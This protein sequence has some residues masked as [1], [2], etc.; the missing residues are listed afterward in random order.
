[1]PII[2]LLTDFGT[3]DG[4]VGE[5]KGVLLSQA[6]DAT[7]VDITH[8]VPPH[9]IEIGRLTLARCWRRFPSGTVHIAVVDPGVGSARAALAVSAGGQFLVGPDNGLLSP[10]LLA[11]DARVVSLDI[12]AGAAPTFHGR[13]V[14]APAA[15]LLARGAE[16]DALGATAPDPIIRRT[17]EPHRAANGEVV[18]EVIAVDRFGNAITNLVGTRGGRVEVSG[19]EVRFRRTYSDLEANEPGAVVGSTGFIEIV[20]RNGRAADVL[21]LARGTRVTLR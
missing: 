1:M 15:V 4:Y 2:T 11:T 18:G 5:M 12:P 20:L 19:R 7:I 8:E 21:R 14:F 6:P 10:A 9:D 16:V 17:P 13:D 3:A